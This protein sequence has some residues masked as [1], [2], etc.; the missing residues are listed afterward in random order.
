M[1]LGH[2]C[3]HNI[4]HFGSPRVVGAEGSGA[5]TPGSGVIHTL[6]E[7]FD[8]LRSTVSKITRKITGNLI[9]VIF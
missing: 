8:L 6:N 4:Q 2:I 7:E 9:N 3:L 1:I 5:A